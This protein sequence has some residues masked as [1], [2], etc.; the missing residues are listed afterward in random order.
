MI[1][2]LALTLTWL[3]LTG[4]VVQAVPDRAPR[5][6][7]LPPKPPANLLDLR[8]TSWHGPNF[9]MP[10]EW[11]V[12]FEADGTLTYSYNN[13]TYRNG[14]WKLEG[15]VLY[16]EMNNKYCENQC[17]VEGNIIRGESWNKVGRRWQTLLHRALPT[18]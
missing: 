9:I 15:N 14:T 13:T 10:G 7:E 17:T 6:P 3:A 11:T 12:L 4:S 16:F 8:G 1:R 18:R 5:E 2:S